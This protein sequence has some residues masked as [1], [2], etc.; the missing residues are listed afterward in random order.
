MSPS[1]SSRS[2]S[3]TVQ[4]RV[5]SLYILAAAAR[6]KVQGNWSVQIPMELE[7]RFALEGLTSC[8]GWII[9]LTEA[10]RYRGCFLNSETI[11]NRPEVET[12]VSVLS[13][14]GHGTG[15]RTVSRCQ[16]L[17]QLRHLPS[18]QT[19]ISR[20]RGAIHCIEWLASLVELISNNAKKCDMGT[21]YL[22][23]LGKKDAQQLHL[24]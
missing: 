1:R 15:T 19:H 20:L 6:L 2:A 14:T 4:V 23:K 5:L 22:V 7:E 12:K 16:S 21:K 13:R 10:S 17:S 9:A 11:V 18:L 8:L 3:S 24:Q